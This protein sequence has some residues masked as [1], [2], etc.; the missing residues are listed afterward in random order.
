MY[1]WRQLSAAVACLGL[2]G[3][4][5]VNFAVPSGATELGVVP[6]GCTLPFVADS[7]AHYYDT[8]GNQETVELVAYKLLDPKETLVALVFWK[9]DAAVKILVNVD[10]KVQEF[11]TIAELKAKYDGPCDIVRGAIAKNPALAPKL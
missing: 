11:A 6:M 9:G 8:D 4:T 3:C 7:A 2:A 10:G 5:G 1:R